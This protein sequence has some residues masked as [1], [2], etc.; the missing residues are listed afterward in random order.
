MPLKLSKHRSREV[1]GQQTSQMFSGSFMSSQASV[2]SVAAAGGDSSMETGQ[3]QQHCYDMDGN[4]HL[5][6]VLQ[7]I[8]TAREKVASRQGSFVLV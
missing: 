7:V 2:E 6:S 1:S 8:F 4:A 3:Q 5:A